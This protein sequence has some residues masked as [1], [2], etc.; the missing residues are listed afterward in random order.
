[1][2]PTSE[3]RCTPKRHRL[4]SDNQFCDS[5]SAD[6]ESPQKK[7][8][9]PTKPNQ[10]NSP[11]PDSKNTQQGTI[12]EDT[13]HQSANNNISFNLD[14][15]DFNVEDTAEGNKLIADFKK[16]LAQF[17]WEDSDEIEG[18]QEIQKSLQDLQPLNDVVYLYVRL[19]ANN[20]LQI[21]TPTHC[22]PSSVLPSN[23][24]SSPTFF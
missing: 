13:N 22:A 19:L 1:M 16:V 4:P 5:Q 6:S 18:V 14:F 3:A 7:M 17:Q 8:A 9:C 2:E 12:N 23:L 24:T 11:A 21:S 20:P 10:A 15:D